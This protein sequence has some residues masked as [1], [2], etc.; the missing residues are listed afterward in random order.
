MKSNRFTGALFCGLLA[1]VMLPPAQGVT[2]RYRES[3][4]WT[5]T[6]PENAGPGWQNVA[7][8]PTTADLGRLNWGGWVGNTVT[9]NDAQQIGSLEIGV[10]ESG[11]LIVQDGGVLTT[12]VGAT[13]GRLYVGNNDPKCQGTL[14]VEE[15]GSVIVGGNMQVG[16]TTLGTAT[17]AGTVTVG[18]PELIMWMQ[19]GRRAVGMV[20]VSGTLTV[21]SHLWLGS[22]SADGIGT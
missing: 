21:S 12:V 3:G 6:A 5:Q 14:I 13:N 18:T 2:I 8:V 22:E 9:L 7:A 20:E 17:I 15:G 10:N 19:I 4:N 1:G 16:S 11:T